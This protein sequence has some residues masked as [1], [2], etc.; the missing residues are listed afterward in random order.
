MTERTY[1]PYGR[2]SLTNPR[3]SPGSPSSASGGAAGAASSSLEDCTLK[4]LPHYACTLKDFGDGR[5]TCVGVFLE[6]SCRGRRHSASL[7]GE[8]VLRELPEYFTA[9]R[10]EFS[11]RRARKVC[12][13]RIWMLRA[14]RMLTLTKRGKFLDT[15]EA[16]AAWKA[17]C[18]LARKFWGE[19]WQF[20][21]VPELHR[22]GGYHLHVALNGFFDVGMLRRIWSKALGGT[23]HESGAD[24]RGNVDLTGA[25]ASPRSRSRI[26][27]Y[28]AKY[29]GKDVGAVLRG[30]RA[31][32][33]SRGIP[34]PRVV[35]WLQALDLGRSQVGIAQRKIRELVDGRLEAN[36][37][38]EWNLGGF[39]G[40]LI[41]PLE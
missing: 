28:L 10:S 4:N 36:G 13:E 6:D 30:R 41:A 17:F 21:V 18:R 26:A 8:P 24:T 15:D 22:E 32:A 40:F 19:R 3:S 9:E 25:V 7:V 2:F 1:K 5:I 39:H 34:A 27:S 38:W 37:W 12:R 31:L 23:G 14:D 11:R 29:L 33:A 35:R 16:W 20:V